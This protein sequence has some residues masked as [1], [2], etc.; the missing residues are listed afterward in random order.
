MNAAGQSFEREEDRLSWAGGVDALL[1]QEREE[2]LQWLRGAYFVILCGS[3]LPEHFQR[4]AAEANVFFR[5]KGPRLDA[6]TGREEYKAVQEQL[7]GLYEQMAESI[8]Q[9]GRA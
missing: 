1:F 8:P 7:Q 6:K 2:R 3:F 4:Y 5:R 9:L